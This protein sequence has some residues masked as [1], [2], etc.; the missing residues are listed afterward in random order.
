MLTSLSIRDVVLIGRLDLSFQPGLSVL[1]GETGAGKSILLDALGLALG[2]RAEARLVRHGA[3]QATVTAA[4]ELPANHLVH[5]LLREQGLDSAD[6]GL[7]LRRVLGADGRSRAF[8][9]DQPVS[10]QLLRDVGELLVEIHGQFESQ[11]L[12]NISSHRGLLDAYGGLDDQTAL[13][14]AAYA[15]WR[16]V[17]QARKDAEAAVESDRRDQDYLRHA[18]EELQVMEPKQGE[19]SELAGRRNMMMNAEKLAEAM[20]A[21]FEELRGERGARPRL[22]AALRQL[23]RVDDKAGGR[24]AAT[25]TALSRSASEAAEAEALLDAAAADLDA[26]PKALEEAE[27]RLFALRALARKHN[28]AVDDLAVLALDFEGRLR[29]LDD[30]DQHLAELQKAEAEA[31]QAYEDSSLAL[32]QKRADASDHLDVAM[33]AELVPL[34]LDKARF[35]TTIE[36]LDE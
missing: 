7:V 30:S 32:S 1:T 4:F 31:R 10:V 19:E 29:T 33:A 22:E 35:S 15:A 16:D 9:N 28:V 8:V 17:E 36:A 23:E 34:K 24:L 13:V 25:I 2:V 18:L 11:R 27:E 14:A 3:G 5:A 21:A 26:D 6:G 20:N 12:L